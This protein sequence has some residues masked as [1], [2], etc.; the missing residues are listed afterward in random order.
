MRV[1]ACALF[2]L[3]TSSACDTQRIELLPGEDART[4]VFDDA[5]ASPEAG[6]A[7]AEAGVSPPD[8]GDAT[9]ADSGE[10]EDAGLPD[11]GEPDLGVSTCVCRYAPC[12]T[13]LECQNAI[14]ASSTC[15]TRG[16]FFCSGALAS[17]CRANLECGNGFV[18]VEN[19]TSTTPCP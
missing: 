3:F 16:D 5:T 18:C 19:E 6:A 14:G 2:A 17:P 4:N 11:T 15:D 9:V 13:D 7:D 8:G 1:I 10:R 12:R